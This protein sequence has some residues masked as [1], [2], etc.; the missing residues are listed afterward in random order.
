MYQHRQIHV[1]IT[2][3]DYRLLRELADLSRD[4]VSSVIRRLIKN[5]RVRLNPRSA[6]TVSSQSDM[7]FVA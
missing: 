2:E 6:A 1:W 7:S 3:T 5:E 4:S